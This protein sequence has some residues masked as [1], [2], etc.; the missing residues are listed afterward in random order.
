[1]NVFVSIL[2][3]TSDS[4]LAKLKSSLKMNTRYI[5]YCKQSNYLRKIQANNS[6]IKV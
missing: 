5:L 3:S 4:F 2:I 1:M 6:N